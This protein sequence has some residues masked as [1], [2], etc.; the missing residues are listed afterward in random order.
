[1]V[2]HIIILWEKD[3]STWFVFTDIKNLALEFASEERNYVFWGEQ[4]KEEDLLFIYIILYIL[5]FVLG[6][7]AIY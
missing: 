4:R 1:M 2:Q 5:N 7:Y 6:I 3:Y